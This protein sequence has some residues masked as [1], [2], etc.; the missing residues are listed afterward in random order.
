MC[1]E[2]GGEGGEGD[3]RTLYIVHYIHEDMRGQWREDMR[4]DMRSGGEGSA[5]L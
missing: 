3:M 5:T 4:E 2:G 1:G